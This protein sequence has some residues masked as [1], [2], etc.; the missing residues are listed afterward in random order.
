MEGLQRRAYEREPLAVSLLHRSRK[1]W[2]GTKVVRRVVVCMKN[3]RQSSCAPGGGEL[4][5][6]GLWLWLTAS[7]PAAL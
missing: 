1:P 6:P 5:G 2:R 7:S 4:A 3:E